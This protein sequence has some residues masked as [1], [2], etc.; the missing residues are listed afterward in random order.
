MKPIIRIKKE[1]T[2]SRYSV[3]QKEKQRIQRRMRQA[4][5]HQHRTR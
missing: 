3:G 5:Q 2:I 4:L 1:T